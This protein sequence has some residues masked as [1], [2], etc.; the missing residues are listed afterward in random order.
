MEYEQLLFLKCQMDGVKYSFCLIKDTEQSK[1]ISEDGKAIGCFL[2]GL[3]WHE[4]GRRAFQWP[5]TQPDGEGCPS[6]DK[7]PKGSCPVHRSCFW[8]LLPGSLSSL[9]SSGTQALGGCC[10]RGCKAA[11]LKQLGSVLV[12]ALATALFVLVVLG[13]INA[14]SFPPSL[15][16]QSVLTVLPRAALGLRL[17]CV[18]MWRFGF[19]VFFLIML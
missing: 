15:S 3:W 8:D 6:G 16:P 5:P 1:V 13:V 14:F 4:V 2:S 18:F 11:S 9:K 12:M 10:R 7:T 17:T 19:W